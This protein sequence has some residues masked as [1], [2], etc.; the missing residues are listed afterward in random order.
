MAQLAIWTPFV[1]SALVLA[2]VLGFGLGALLFAAPLLGWPLGRWWQAAAQVHAHEFLFGWAGLMV[3]GV[4][5]Y[6]LPRLRGRALTNPEQAAA[7]LWLLLGGLL[8][9]ALSQPGLDLGSAFGLA[10]WARTGLILS[11]VLELLGASL[12]LVVLA[13]TLRGDPPLS[14]RRGFSEILPFLVVS[15]ASLWLA[16]A[17]NMAA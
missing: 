4:G 16:L 10:A 2:A 6:F 9:R 15:F 13:R 1:W 11:A 14:D 12:A 17:L 7:V 3:L 5:F 8:L